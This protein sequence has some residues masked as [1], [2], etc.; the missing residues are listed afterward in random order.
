MKVPIGKIKT[1]V[2]LAAGLGSRL[3]HITKNKPKCLVEVNGKPLLQRTIH[4]LIANGIERIII[5]AG[6][7]HE[8]IQHFVESREFQAE[9]NILYNHIFDKTNNIY[10]LWMAYAGLRLDEPYV[11]LEAD[12]IYPEAM[13]KQFVNEPSIALDI[14]NPEIHSGTTAAVNSKG[15]VEYLSFRSELPKTDTIYK[16][17]NITSFSSDYSKLLFN[18]LNEY[19]LAGKT[20]VYYEYVIQEIIKK[21]GATFKMADFSKVYWDEIDSRTD[22]ARVQEKMK[23]HSFSVA[24]T[25]V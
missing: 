21:H 16:T 13:L 25:T 19:I 14:Y 24:D 22:L 11:L 1:A 9:I 8:L 23:S 18:E 3:E 5:L 17:V 20:N 6:Y 2:V 12:L 7:K 10:S 15:F 4:N